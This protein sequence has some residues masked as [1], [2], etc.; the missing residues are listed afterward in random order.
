MAE[1]KDAVDTKTFLKMMLDFIPLILF[2]GSYFITK[3]FDSEEA[4][5]IAQA[6]LMGGV[7]LALILSWVIFKKVSKVMWFTTI[8]VLVLGGLTLW[9]RDPRFTYIKPSLVNG[10]FALGLAISILIGKNGMK[11]LFNDAFKLPD[12]A[13]DHITWRWVG[14]FAF[15]AILNEIV[16][17][18]IAV[19]NWIT[20]DKWVLLKFPGGII[21]TVA[22][23]MI[24]LPY[25]LKHTVTDGDED[26]DAEPA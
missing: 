17:R 14:F 8:L 13:W 22:M 25:T 12:Y 19:D 21:L 6:V 23:M 26:E 3:R 24:N 16:W 1:M 4:I 5:Y 9:L 11:L 18:Q 10:A 2:A 7:T 15:M 20:E